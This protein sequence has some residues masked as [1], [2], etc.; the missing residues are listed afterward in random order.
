MKSP[1]LVCASLVSGALLLQGSAVAGQKRCDE[2]GSDCVCSEPLDNSDAYKPQVHDPSD[3]TAKECGSWNSNAPGQGTSSFPV[4]FPA[5]ATVKRVLYMA[6]DKGGAAFVGGLEE[7]RRNLT[8]KTI[9]I[10]SYRNYGVDHAP[11]G[12]VKIARIGD[13]SRVSVAWQS[14]WEPGWEAGGNPDSRPSVS[15]IAKFNDTGGVVDCNLPHM[16]NASE[17]VRFTDCQSHWCRFEICHDHNAA[18]GEMAM[19]AQWVQVGGSKKMG[20]YA[21]PGS[22]GPYCA[23]AKAA[24]ATFVGNVEVMEFVTTGPPP[25][26]GGSI[27]LSHA[28]MAITDY[29]PNFWI[30]PAYEIE[31]EVLG[32]SRG[33][34]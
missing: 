5:G 6:T 29:D 14:A 23:A 22:Y 34:E 4:R 8:N 19:R 15:W 18:T 32:A 12:N 21:G 13:A 1:K 24:T 17:H 28:M 11:P 26:A 31:G 16:G 10:R 20:S 25:S 30:G 3:S 2:L 33:G 9:C 7:S 27:Y